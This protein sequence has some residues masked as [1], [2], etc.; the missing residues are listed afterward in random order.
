MKRTDDY[1]APWPDREGVE[2]IRAEMK[3]TMSPTE[4]QKLLGPNG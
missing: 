3:Q 4:W 1:G 2:R